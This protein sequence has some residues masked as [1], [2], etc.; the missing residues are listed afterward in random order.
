[1][2][3]ADHINAV[4]PGYAQEI[5]TPEFGSGLQDFLKTRKDSISGI[6]NGIDTNQW[7]PDSDPFLA[8]N[9]TTRNLIKRKDNK[10]QL[11]GEVN[12]KPELKT[13]LIA[14]ISR[15]DYQKGVDLVPNAFD[16]IADKP[17]QAIILGTGDHA[18]EAEVRALEEKYPQRVRVMI[19][20]DAPLARR[21][22]AG[23]DT[24]L[25]PSR[26]EPCGL[27]Q[28]IAMRYGNVPIA[29][30]TGGLRDTIVDY[31][32]TVETSTSGQQEERLQSTGFLYH[33]SS[34]EALA[35][36]ILRALRVYADQR[37]WRGLQ[38]R[39]MKRDFSWRKSAYQYLELYK[40]IL[41]PNLSH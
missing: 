22:Y 20:F 13:P 23:A 37:R 17:W 15:M 36:A 35:E 14:M 38:I 8:A 25:I 33:D 9:F 31:S 16:K 1:L 39:A 40:A 32:E 27:A 2:L 5:M 10:L 12:L 21:I 30:A 18:I 26:Y 6:L 3:T 41:K 24:L 29:R 11:L 19:L 4:S 28:M 34:S 7:D